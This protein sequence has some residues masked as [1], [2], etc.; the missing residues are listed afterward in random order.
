MGRFN[1]GFQSVAALGLL[2][3]LGCNNSEQAETPAP[4]AEAVVHDH[5]SEGPH[6]G[7]LIELGNEAYHAELLHD[8]ATGTVT[9]YVLDST[10]TLA[11]AIDASEILVNFSHDGEAEQFTVAADPQSSDPDG[12]SSRFV[13]TDGELAEELEEHEEGQLVLIIDGKQY[14]GSI[15]LDH[16]HKE[17]EHKH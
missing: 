9:I 16:D 1:F 15:H 17:H 10:L 13:S 12:K 14:R 2:V 11:V 5:P 3:I 8:D 7:A 4:P 6:H